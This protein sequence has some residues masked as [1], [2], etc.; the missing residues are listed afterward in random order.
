[1]LRYSCFRKSKAIIFIAIISVL[2]GF[3]A[4]CGAGKFQT[5]DPI[6]DD[7]RPGPE[8]EEQEINIEANAFNR[9]VVS[10]IEQCLD[11]A[12]QI[13]KLIGRPK[14]ALNVNAF[15]E[16]D[17]SSWYTNR[18]S[19]K[20]MSLEEFAAGP[21][22]GAKPDPTSTWTVIRAKAEGV[23]PG[24]SI[25]DSRGEKFV[26]KFDPP[27]YR[28]LATGAEVVSTK[29]FH[30]AGYNVPENYIVYFDPKILKLGEEVKFTDEKGRKRYMNQADL[31]A[32]LER[33]ELLPDGRIR[34]L[35]SKYLSGS[36]KGPLKYKGTRKDD[37]NDIV[38]HQHRRELRGL[39]VISAWLNH[40]DTK[41]N[42]SLDVYVEDGYMKHYLIDFGSTLGSQGNEPMPPDVGHEN[43]ID[44]HAIVVNMLTLGFYVRSWE[45]IEPI[46]YP[47]IGYFRS[48]I[49]YPQKYKFIVPN[50]A[51]ENMT[52]RDGYWGA[53]QVMS[54]TDDQLKA[55]VAEGQY[56]DPEAAEYLLKT[57]TERRDIVGRYWFSRVNPL[58]KFEMGENS[59]GQQEMNFA[60][61]AIESGLE[62]AEQ[63]E[64]RCDMMRDGRFVFGIEPFKGTSISFLP[65]QASPEFTSFEQDLWELRIYTKRGDLGR[66]MKPVE[67]Y[68]R[69]NET[70]GKFSLVGVRH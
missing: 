21:N 15:D 61:L 11:L 35:A 66:W 17:D 58:D 37:P 45:R 40:Y 43:T 6:P 32:I 22:K 46:R 44:P 68:L 38:P 57:L 47:S 27:G 23:T 39:R 12:R 59:E 10:Q 19:M 60:D 41:A 53:K 63:T 31:D 56:S 3:I 70:S 34:A 24:F 4:G 33:I 14:E 48:D 69:L 9:Q 51:F 54:I 26:I 20:R 49:F 42:N 16:V 18:N 62:S 65:I 8:P 36:L 50:P 55:A 29:L 1:M 2:A 5:P 28:E 64:Y 7:R 25:V 67:V 52:D 13:R 30:A